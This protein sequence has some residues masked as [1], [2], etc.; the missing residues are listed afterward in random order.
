M[1]VA[2][3]VLVDEVLKEIEGG[4]TWAK[5]SSVPSNGKIEVVLDAKDA[6]RF[7]QV[8]REEL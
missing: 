1:K 7:C 3:A 8:L 2:D 4:V 6:E 5:Q